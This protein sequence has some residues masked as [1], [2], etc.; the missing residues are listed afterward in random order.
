MGG[1]SIYGTGV[2]IYGLE[3]EPPDCVVLTQWLTL[4][5]IPVAPLRRAKCRYHG[6]AFSDGHTDAALRFELVERLPLSTSSICATYFLSWAAL[7]ATI[8]PIAW[9]IW[10]T[11]NRAATVPEMIAVLAFTVGLALLPFFVEWR[12]KQVLEASRRQEQ[13]DADHQAQAAR[14]AGALTAWQS[15]H[16]LSE[17]TFLLA[18]VVGLVPG[19]AAAV[20]WGWGGNVLKIAGLLSAVLA[21]GAVYVVDRV[22]VRQRDSSKTPPNGDW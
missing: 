13:R 5:F 18:G 17:R 11:Q 16:A 19:V 15:K 14:I 12:H 3:P 20:W 10:R 7:L 6:E 8:G 1:W 9:M 2:R 21:M 4:F 22:L